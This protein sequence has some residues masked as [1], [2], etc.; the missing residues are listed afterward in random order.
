CAQLSASEPV[1]YER[2]GADNP[3]QFAPI[4]NQDLAK[5]KVHLS[6]SSEFPDVEP[7]EPSSPFRGLKNFAENINRIMNIY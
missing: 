1:L 7:K 6:Q 4:S 3:I 2:I 5:W